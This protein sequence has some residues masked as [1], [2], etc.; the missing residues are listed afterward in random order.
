MIVTETAIVV[1]KDL[2]IGRWYKVSE[3]E[4]FKKFMVL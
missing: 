2:D 4:F 1:T 3:E